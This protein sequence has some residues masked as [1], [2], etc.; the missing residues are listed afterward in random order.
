MLFITITWQRQSNI[1]I[2]NMIPAQTDLG[3]VGGQ[4]LTSKKSKLQSGCCSRLSVPKAKVMRSPGFTFTVQQQSLL[5]GQLPGYPGELMAPQVSVSSPPHTKED[6]HKATSMKNA[7]K[8]RYEECFENAKM[9][10]KMLNVFHFFGQTNICIST[11]E[12]HSIT[13]IIA[14][15]NSPPYQEFQTPRKQ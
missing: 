9:L 11:K 15:N 4:T 14:E 12:P 7:L 8:A 10:N 1:C 5:G 3:A 13:L 2:M 6:R